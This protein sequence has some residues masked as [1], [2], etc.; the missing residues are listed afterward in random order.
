MVEKYALFIFS[1]E[2]ILI[3]YY[4]AD[5]QPWDIEDAIVSY[6]DNV[7]MD[8]DNYNHYR[9]IKDIMNSFNL[10]YEIV[11]FTSYLMEDTK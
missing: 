11:N 3:K 1:D 7:I 10:E 4:S 8:A 9:L 6:Y 2:N 5:I